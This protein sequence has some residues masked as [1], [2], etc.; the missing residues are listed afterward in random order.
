MPEI[1]STNVKI[2][3]DA[4]KLKKEAKESVKALEEIQDKQHELSEDTRLEIQSMVDEYNRLQSNLQKMSG[5]AYEKGKF[6]KW[7]KE[8]VTNLEASIARVKDSLASFTSDIPT[9]QLSEEVRNILG[10]ELEVA[11]VQVPI[12]PE[13][14]DD[15][16]EKAKSKLDDL[17]KKINKI[18]E[19]WKTA[20]SGKSVN[21]IARVGLALMGIRSMFTAIRKAMN[22]YLA[23]NDKLRQ[24]LDGI[25]Y[26]L[27]S[28]FAPILE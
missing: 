2:T 28:L 6:S 19:N 13:V 8:V 26:A 22:T 10:R 12:E 27:G 16:I 5:A 3:A 20:F 15:G 17:N 9:N 24:K 25:W 23:Q 4:S 21:G 7:S 18:K 11:P 1:L 14:K